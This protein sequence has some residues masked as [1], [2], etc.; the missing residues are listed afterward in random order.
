M[1]VY[2]PEM[3]RVQ[4]EVV[5]GVV[6]LADTAAIPLTQEA[7]AELSCCS[8]IGDVRIDSGGEVR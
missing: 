3:I 4:M 2:N 5:T 7:A 1:N 8:D 6:G